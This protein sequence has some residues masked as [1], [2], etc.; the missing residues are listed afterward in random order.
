MQQK[1]ARVKEEE[2]ESVDDGG[3][4]LKAVYSAM[5]SMTPAERAWQSAREK[6]KGACVGSGSGCVQ[7]TSDGKAR[8][9]VVSLEYMKVSPAG[10]VF[11]SIRR[12]GFNKLCW[13]NVI[14]SANLN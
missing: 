7:G 9:E 5:S 2:L 14:I 10:D 12:S 8:H 6:E 13:R 1:E 3:S 4:G 11:G